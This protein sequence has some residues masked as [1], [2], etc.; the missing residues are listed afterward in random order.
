VGKC[1]S[2][3]KFHLFFFKSALASPGRSRVGSAVYV[4]SLLKADTVRTRK[5]RKAD[6][7]YVLC[8]P[9]PYSM[10][11]AIHIPAASNID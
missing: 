5:G 9:S 3:K 11:F 4:F 7:S 6:S 2:E 8:I 10:R 1:T